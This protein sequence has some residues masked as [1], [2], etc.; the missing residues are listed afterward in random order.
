MS[1]Y[2]KMTTKKYVEKYKLDDPNFSNKFNTD[3]FLQDLNEELQNRIQVEKENRKKQ[4]L[5]YSFRI[6][7]I[8]ITE[9]QNKFCAISYKKI[10]GPLRP[11]L[12]S[13]FY[14]KYV[15]P[16]RARDFPEEHSK[17]LAKREANIKNSIRDGVLRENQDAYTRAKLYAQNTGNYTYVHR[18]KDYI[19][20]EVEKIFK[21][22][23]PKGLD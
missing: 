21:E 1:K 13:A 23:Y 9:M 18:V 15:V 8:I 22:R 17:I 2:I 5:E 7:N 4:G 14:A 20:V 16:S 19:E 6:F 3:L 11:E 10:G 12:W